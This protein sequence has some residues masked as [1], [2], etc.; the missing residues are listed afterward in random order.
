MKL[1]EVNTS[2]I[3]CKNIAYTIS[4]FYNTYDTNNVSEE[5]I[6]NK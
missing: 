1:A 2:V 5:D 6:Y 3:F 4:L